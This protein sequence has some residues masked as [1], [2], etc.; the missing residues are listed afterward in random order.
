MELNYQ[1]YLDGLMFIIEYVRLNCS[2]L[3]L[4]TMLRL[5]QG[6]HYAL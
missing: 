5:M 1:H 3:H 6:A 2:P 4:M